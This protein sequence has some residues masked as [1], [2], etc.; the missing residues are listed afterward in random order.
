MYPLNIEDILS[1]SW[2]RDT[3]LAR[4]REKKVLRRCGIQV[5]L[6]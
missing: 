6:T 5:D 1:K 3:I 2:L 4:L